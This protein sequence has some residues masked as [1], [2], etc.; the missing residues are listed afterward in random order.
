MPNPIGRLLYPPIDPENAGSHFPQS[1][2]FNV[3]GPEN[4][5]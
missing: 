3:L 1:L 2:R 4:I 5:L